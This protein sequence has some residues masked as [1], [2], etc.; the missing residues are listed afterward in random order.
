MEQVFG[1][2][3]IP[4]SIDRSVP[5]GH[6]GL[7]RGL[8]AL[9]RCAVDPDAPRRGPARLAAHAGAAAAARARRPARG[10][11]PARRA[12]TAAEEARAL[13]ESE[14]WTLDELDRLREAG[15]GAALLAE[16]ERQLERLFAAPYRRRP[17]ILRGPEL[18]DPRASSRRRDAL[19][20]AARRAGGGPAHARW[21]PSACSAVLA[22]CA[23]RLGETAAARPRSGRQPE[24]IRARRFEAV[25]VCGL[26]EGEFPRGAAPRALPVR[27]GPA[28]DRRSPAGCVLPVREDRLD[29]ERYLFYVCG[30]RAERL[31]VL[32]S[33]SSDEEGNPQARSF[34]VE[35]VRDLLA[36]GAPELASAR[37][38]T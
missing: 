17:P 32:S 13:W 34:F 8:L 14:H 15:G 11:G 16:L 29:R 37:C 18:D 23:V 7:G 38:R 19:A 10:A 33:R 35:D 20:R 5:L 4:F 1:A 24:A 22:S 27:R 25:F 26:Q 6:T 31:L 21:S 28:R 36:P 12:P 3:G 2:Y 9:V 30:S